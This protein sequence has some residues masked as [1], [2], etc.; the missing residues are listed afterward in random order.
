VVSLY[1]GGMSVRDIARHCQRAM[2]IEISHD[3]ISKIT[4]GVLEEV[5][6]WQSRPLEAIYP[7]VYIDALVAKVRAGGSVRNKAVN[8]AVGVDCGGV[9]HVLGI[10]VAPCTA[11]ELVAGA[12]TWGLA[13]GA[14][15]GRIA[16]AADRAVHAVLEELLIVL[17]TLTEERLAYALARPSASHRRHASTITDVLVA[18]CR[19]NVNPPGLTG[20]APSANTLPAGALRMALC[21]VSSPWIRRSPGR[22]L[23]R[24]SRLLRKSRR[25]LR[26]VPPALALR[27]GHVR[28]ATILSSRWRLTASS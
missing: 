27:R 21:R 6:A 14:G 25:P 23:R 9:R 26:A 24:L 28:N 13:G 15:C 2:G 7:V 20:C 1:S 22:F 19:P 10:W 5:R 8:I 16:V 4:D 12:V 11:S 17:P 18:W 3:T